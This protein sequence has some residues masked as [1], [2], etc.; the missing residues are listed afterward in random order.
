M[1]T[2]HVAVNILFNVKIV[3]FRVNL[4][5]INFRRESTRDEFQGGIAALANFHANAII[6]F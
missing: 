1:A 6:A 4:S 5:K 3:T 2:V